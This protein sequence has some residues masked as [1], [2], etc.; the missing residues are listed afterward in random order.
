VPKLDFSDVQDF[1]AIPKGIYNATVFSIELKKAQGDGSDYYSWQFAI[2]DEGFKNRRVWMNTSLKPQA[3]WKLKATLESLDGAPIKGEFD[4]NPTAYF[5]RPCSISLGTQEY[6]VGSGKM[7][8]T[9]ED[10]FKAGSGPATAASAA[11]AKVF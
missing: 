1:A 9:V 5:G 10:V 8:N 3:L 2:Q 4:F 11:P 6:P 7:S